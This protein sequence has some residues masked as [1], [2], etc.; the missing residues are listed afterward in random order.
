MNDAKDDEAVERWL[1]SALVDEPLR[2]DGF[3]TA[4]LDR[5]HRRAD[6]RRTLLTIG[7]VAAAIPVFTSIPGA[8]VLW[9]SVTPASLAA[10]MMLSALCSLVWIATTD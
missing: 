3:T 9:A 8:S 10:M 7:W 5:I 6:R 4:V 2:D 1:T